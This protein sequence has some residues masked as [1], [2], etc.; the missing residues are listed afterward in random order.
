MSVSSFLEYTIFWAIQS[1]FS[2]L[3]IIE[4]EGQNIE[5]W[6]MN[7]RRSHQS[8]MDPLLPWE[9]TRR[10]CMKRSNSKLNKSGYFYELQAFGLPPQHLF[11]FQSFWWSGHCGPLD[12]PRMLTSAN[13]N[14]CLN[15][16]AGLVHHF[17]YSAGYHRF[18]KLIETKPWRGW[19]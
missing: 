1:S 15:Y 19:V 7:A 9:A 2:K 11:P 8:R 4:D 16:L 6:M 3:F 5:P 17:T 18:S 13:W 10:Q 12:H 14:W